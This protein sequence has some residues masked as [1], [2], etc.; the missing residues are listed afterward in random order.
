VLSKKIIDMNVKQKTLLLTISV[1]SLLTSTVLMTAVSH[2]EVPKAEAMTQ[3]VAQASPSLIERTWQ[4]DNNQ[5][6]VQFFK[7]NNVYN[8]KIVWLPSGAET[9]DVKNSDPNLRSRNLIGLMMFKGFTY[10]PGKKQW[11]GG[12]MYIPQRG[13]SMQPKIWLEGADRLKVKISMGIMS[14]TL[15]LAA[16]K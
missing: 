4:P 6:R 13:M 9:K 7:E 1:T 5:F 3:I 15:T 14:R 11:T 10:D 12:T 2:S 8:G 16:I